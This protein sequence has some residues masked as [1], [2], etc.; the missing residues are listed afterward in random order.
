M[1]MESSVDWGIDK[2]KTDGK[3]CSVI[4]QDFCDVEQQFT[5]KKIT[6]SYIIIIKKL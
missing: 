2:K 1:L 3:F 4:C 6:L 5:H